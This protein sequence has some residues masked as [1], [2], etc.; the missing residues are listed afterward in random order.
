MSELIKATR[1][2]FGNNRG[3]VTNY[4]GYL[5]DPLN[6]DFDILT[7]EYMARTLCRLPRWRNDVLTEDMVTVA[8]HSFAVASCCVDPRLRLFYFLHDWSEVIT[9]DIPS[10]LLK[11]FPELKKF[12]NNLQE[13]IWDYYCPGW[14]HI[15]TQEQL[16]LYHTIDSNVGSFEWV[17]FQD[18]P[19]SEHTVLHCTRHVG[20]A[21]Y[22]NFAAGAFLQC[23]K[24]YKLMWDTEVLPLLPTVDSKDIPF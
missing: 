8:A 18:V 1:E 24:N 15:M 12:C 3:A 4:E 20:K 5:I 16:Q 23:Y 22:K 7:P 11:L 21:L 13:Q 10:P 17:T 14:R 9:N 2:V 19:A 6:L